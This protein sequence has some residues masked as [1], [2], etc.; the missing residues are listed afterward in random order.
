[1]SSD[2]QRHIDHN[3]DAKTAEVRKTHRRLSP[4]GYGTA[5]GNLGNLPPGTPPA[6]AVGSPPYIGSV[7]QSTQANDARA[8]VERKAQAGV[9]VSRA[10]NVGGPNSVLNQPQVYG[11]SE[12]QLGA[13]AEGQPVAAKP[14][15]ATTENHGIIYS[16]EVAKCQTAKIVENPLQDEAGGASCVQGNMLA[17]ASRGA[18]NPMD[19][20]PRLPPPDSTSQL[21]SVGENCIH[22][23]LEEVRVGEGMPGALHDGQPL[24]ETDTDVVN[25][26]RSNDCRF[27]TDATRMKREE[28]GIIRSVTLKH[29]APLVTLPFTVQRPSPQLVPSVESSTLEEVREHAVQQN[30]NENQSIVPIENLQQKTDWQDQPDT[31]W[32]AASVIM[33]QVYQVLA[34]GA[35]AVWV[36][37]AFVRK[38]ERVDFPGQWAALGESCG[39]QTVEWIRS[40]LI[41]DQGAQHTLDGDVEQKQVAWKSF[42]RREAEKK[43]APP[44][45]YEVVLIQKRL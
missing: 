12:G 38:G 41:E 35:V 5:Q 4:D 36:L 27:I 21:P 17:Q 3:N 37:K 9:D 40:W 23:G 45:D 1:V 16:Q 32:S 30:A 18:R 26:V 43:G 8:R 28:S 10:V 19:L 7:N 42:F 2:G 44:I 29:S 34:P 11:V 22:T 14:A 24:N 13:M 20:E 31:F 33:R 39:F 15:L 25:A 6:A